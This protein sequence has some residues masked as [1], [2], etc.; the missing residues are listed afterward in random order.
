MSIRTL[1]AVALVATAAHADP[2]AAMDPEVAAT[3]RDL[4][5]ERPRGADTPI[6][7]VAPPAKGT[8]LEDYVRTVSAVRDQLRGVDVSCGFAPCLIRVDLDRDGRLENVLQVAVQDG[9]VGFAILAGKSVLLVGA[10]ADAGPYR[11]DLSPVLDWVV[12]D[13]GL[14]LSDERDGVTRL[15]LVDGRAVIR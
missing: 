1:L 12:D 5:A 3:V 11:D 15:S 6:P 7:E 10:G 4:V 9:R 14:R 2:Y 8:H 13:E